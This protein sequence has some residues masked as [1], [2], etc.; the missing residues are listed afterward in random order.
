MANREPSPR[1]LAAG[2]SFGS[3]GPTWGDVPLAQWI[4]RIVAFVIDALVSIV[5]ASF[6]GAPCC[7][8]NG[9]LGFAVF[10]VILF[11]NNGIALGLTGQSLGKL[12]TYSWVVK[13]SNGHTPGML[14]GIWRC[15]GYVAVALCGVG[16]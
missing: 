10:L 4:A 14:L 2:D 12:C 9:W 3:P 15:F 5:P 8:R 1:Y 11:A 7:T 6:T 16:F 13:R